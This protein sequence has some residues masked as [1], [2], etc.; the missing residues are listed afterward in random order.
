MAEESRAQDRAP[1][2]V[3]ETPGDEE[4]FS[5]DLQAQ[6]VAERLG[7]EYV[8]LEHFEIDPE[9]CIGCGRCV[10]ACPSGA[11]E[12]ERKQPHKIDQARGIKCGACESV[13]P[14]DAI[15]RI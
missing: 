2:L 10:K 8:D 5:E 1:E 6:R 4:V 3:G 9:L 12:G 7:L 15:R 14:K 11:I 13:C